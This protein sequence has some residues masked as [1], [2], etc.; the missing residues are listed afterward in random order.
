MKLIDKDVLVAEIEKRKK[1]AESNCGGYKSYG[2]HR[3]NSC[4]VG[5]YEEFLE[6][7]NTLEV[8]EVDLENRIDTYI[9]G[10][11]SEGCDGGMISDTNRDIGG[12]TYFDLIDLAKHFFK[13]G[14]NVQK[15]E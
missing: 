12:V 3:C 5:F 9:N 4:V 15:E 6:I 14:L 8:K 11:Y 1:E 10:H 13:L 7:L 2:E